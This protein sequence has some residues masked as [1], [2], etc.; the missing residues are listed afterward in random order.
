[1]LDRYVDLHKSIDKA[2]VLI[3]TCNIVVDKCLKNLNTYLYGNV[4]T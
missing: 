3:I 2:G 4:V 1:M